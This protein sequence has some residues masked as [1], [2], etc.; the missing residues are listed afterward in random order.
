MTE[1]NPVKYLARGNSFGLS[2]LEL[3][4]RRTE[5]RVRRITQLKL[6]NVIFCLTMMTES[7]RLK[8]SWD[9][10]RRDTVDTGRQEVPHEKRKLLRPSMS[11]ME[12]DKRRSLGVKRVK[13]RR[14]VHLKR[15]C[16][17]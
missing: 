4:A 1:K 13:G 6:E 12:T 2:W 8:A 15:W 17:R 10:R 11:P 7:M 3:N 9:E 14:P 5:A 16:G